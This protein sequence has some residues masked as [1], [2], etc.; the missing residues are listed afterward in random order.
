MFNVCGWSSKDC[1][2]FSL[3]E[4]P[5]NIELSKKRQHRNKFEPQLVY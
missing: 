5:S 1:E 2:Y 4:L 3:R